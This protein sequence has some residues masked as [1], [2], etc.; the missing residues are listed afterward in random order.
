MQKVKNTLWAQE[1]VEKVKHKILTTA[2]QMYEF[3]SQANYFL[4]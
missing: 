3:D 4:A 2:H 1:I